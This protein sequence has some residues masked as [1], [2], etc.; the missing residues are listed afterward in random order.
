MAAAWPTGIV[1]RAIDKGDVDAWV[2]LLQ[3]VERVDDEGENYDADD[4]LEELADSKLDP[5]LDTLGLWDG[6]R[7]VGYAKVSTRPGAVEVDRVWMEGRIDPDWRRRG[8]GRRL[9]EWSC[10]RATAAHAEH[11]PDV[12]GACM[13]GANS[14]NAGAAA[15]YVDAGF[16][17]S[18]YFSNLKRD[19]TQPVPIAE[20][21]AGL[22]VSAFDARWDEATRVAHNEAFRD[23]WGSRPRDAED[24]RTWVSGSRS[25]RA[26]LCRLALDGDQVAGYVLSYEH[27]AE[28]E[29]TG[30]RELWIGQVG[31]QR[32]YR[33]RGVARALLAQVLTAAAEAGYRRVGLG[34]DAENPTGALGL[35]ER[36]GFVVLR[37]F[38]NYARPMK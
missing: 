29:A 38:A 7:M 17:P 33:G 37:S 19:L 30:V 35:Y 15:L 21:P 27:A 20:P 3:A 28:A 25:F 31:T 5:A 34:V 32:P 36:L 4:L 26:P 22:M 24:W 11:N 2:A 14:E 10:A 8:L 12:P 13:A 1:A 18:R 9:L 6:E 16:A 23:H